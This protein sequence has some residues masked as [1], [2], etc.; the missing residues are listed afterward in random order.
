MKKKIIASGAAI[1]ACIYMSVSVYAGSWLK[2]GQQWTYIENGMTVKN[3]WINDSGEIYYV[4]P[5]T[6][7]MVTGWKY[8]EGIPYLFGADG[9]L[10]YGGE[11]GNSLGWGGMYGQNGAQAG[12]Q[13]LIKE[14]AEMMGDFS[15]CSIETKGK[16]YEELSAELCDRVNACRS[17]R[18]MSS[19]A[20]NDTLSKVAMERAEELSRVYSHMR[21]DGTKC[22]TLMKEKGYT[23]RRAAENIAYGQGSVNEVFDAWMNS[24]G[25]RKNILGDYREMGI[26][27]YQSNGVYYWV[28]EFGSSAY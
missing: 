3:G 13:C 9:A 2:L 24:A 25:H 11:I 18:G 8:I 7:L 16:S 27:V 19:Y 6:N 26:G 20:I 1:I 14:A 22:F 10:I 17:E 5:E 15:R 23:Y 12:G 4:D 21:P 28:Q